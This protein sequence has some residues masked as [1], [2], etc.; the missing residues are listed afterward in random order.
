MSSPPTTNIGSQASPRETPHPGARVAGPAAEPPRRRGGAKHAS[1]ASAAQQPAADT[2]A[3]TGAEADA[4]RADSCDARV[5]IEMIAASAFLR[6]ER[7]GFVDGS[8]DDDWFEAEREVD[9]M[10]AMRDAAG[11]PPSS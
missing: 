8:P 3:V 10:L 4:D 5:R 2:A 9:L 1:Q 11:L 7:R 6:A